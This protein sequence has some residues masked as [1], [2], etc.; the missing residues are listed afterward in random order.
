MDTLRLVSLKSVEIIYSREKSAV[1]CISIAFSFYNKFGATRKYV[2][3]VILLHMCN[4][5]SCATDKL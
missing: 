3:I 4:T 5:T 2:S 1:N